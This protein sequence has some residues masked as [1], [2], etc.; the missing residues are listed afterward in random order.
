[1]VQLST[2]NYSKKFS[3]RGGKLILVR[4]S[5]MVKDLMDR[6]RFDEIFK[7]YNTREEAVNIFV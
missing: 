6:A 5:D 3:D 7:F 1:M 2:K 4:S